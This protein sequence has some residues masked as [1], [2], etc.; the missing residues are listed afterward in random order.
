MGNSEVS[1][2]NVSTQ[3]SRQ[4]DEFAKQL[5]LNLAVQIADCDVKGM[6]I[7]EV[8]PRMLEQAQLLA[9]ICELDI[10][11]RKAPEGRRGKMAFAELVSNLFTRAEA[12]IIE[13][14]EDFT[15]QANVHF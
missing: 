15:Y 14:E 1:T 11:F 5:D 10:E 7:P 13:C 3:T 2:V 9:R 6:P 4:L 8:T 12:V